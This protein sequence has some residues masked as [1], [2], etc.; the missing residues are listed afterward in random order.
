MQWESI[1][2]ALWDSAETQQMRVWTDCV[3]LTLVVY[4]VFKQITDWL[5]PSLLSRLKPAELLLLRLILAHIVF[6]ELSFASHMKSK[7]KLFCPS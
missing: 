2:R 6:T 5:L 3:K 1:K 4:V 7:M